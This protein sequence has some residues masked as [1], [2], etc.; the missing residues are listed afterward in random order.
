MYK[1]TLRMTVRRDVVDPLHVTLGFASAVNAQRYERP[2]QLA[3]V[4]DGVRIAAG[5][6]VQDIH[7]D[8]WPSLVELVDDTNRLGMVAFACVDCAGKRN[9][10]TSD[11]T[12]QRINWVAGSD[13]HLPLHECR[14]PEETLKLIT[15]SEQRQE[16]VQFDE[17]VGQV[18]VGALPDAS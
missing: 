17:Q 2:S 12:V 16:Q 13:I 14:E 15:I 7:V 9:V 18:T 4:E 1:N 10:S 6:G 3:F 5:D 8:G 11:S